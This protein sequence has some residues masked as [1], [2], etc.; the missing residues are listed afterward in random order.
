MF[1]TEMFTTPEEKLVCA[2]FGERPNGRFLSDE[3]REVVN[4]LLDEFTNR[5]GLWS[6]KGVKVLRLRFGFEPLTEAEKAQSRKFNTRSLK[7]TGAYF[8]ITKERARQIEAKTLRWLRY[9]IWSRR[10]LPY[11]DKA[12]AK[13]AQIRIGRAE[14]DKNRLAFTIKEVSQLLGVSDS[15]IYKAV[16]SGQITSFRFGRKFLIS[17]AALERLLNE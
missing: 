7:E 8:N 13:K 14:M 6:K 2:I 10:L 5:Y 3:E 1:I 4:N 17:R 15:L 11:R 9:P 16:H 12:I